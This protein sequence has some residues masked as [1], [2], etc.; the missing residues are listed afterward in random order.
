M[1]LRGRGANREAFDLFNLPYLYG[2]NCY[3]IKGEKRAATLD[4]DKVHMTIHVPWKA[5]VFWPSTMNQILLPSA[6]P[7]GRIEESGRIGKTLRTL[8]QV[9]PGMQSGFTDIWK[10]TRHSI[11]MDMM[12]HSAARV[13]TSGLT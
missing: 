7:A 6:L 4:A 12:S 13:I 5:T 10:Q 9:K 11:C 3:Y 1:G 8:C 2:S